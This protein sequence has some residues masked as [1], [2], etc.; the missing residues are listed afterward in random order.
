M[1]SF[2]FS[3][4]NRPPTQN[5]VGG[6]SREINHKDPSNKTM[7][8]RHLFDKASTPY[9]TAVHINEFFNTSKNTTG[10]KSKLIRDMFKLGYFDPEF[11]TKRIAKESPFAKLV[12]IDGLIVPSD[13]FKE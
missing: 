5:A 6:L 8:L 7:S 11:S 4:T 1:H 9:T 2:P 3:E 13:M 12:S 10:Q